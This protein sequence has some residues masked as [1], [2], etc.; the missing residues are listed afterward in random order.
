MNKKTIITILLAL[1]AMAGQAKTFKTIKNP[2]TM[3]YVN[4]NPGGLKAREI[5][6]IVAGIGTWVCL[7]MTAVMTQ[8]PATI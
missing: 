4:V 5:I 2:E 1:V 6:F 7:G 3:A 8:V